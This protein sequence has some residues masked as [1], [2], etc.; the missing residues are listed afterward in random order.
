MPCLYLEFIAMKKI[1]PLLS[2]LFLLSNSQSAV[3]APTP[4][5]SILENQVIVTYQDALGKLHTAAS[6][7]ISIT[8]RKVQAA[9]LTEV[10]GMEQKVAAIPNMEVDSVHRLQNTGNVRS[11][12]QLTAENVTSSTTQ[13]ASKRIARLQLRSESVTDTIDAE[14]MLIFYDKNNNGIV[15]ADEATPITEI[16]L[17]AGEKANLIVR[18]MLPK[19]VKKDDRLDVTLQAKDKDNEVIITSK[20]WIK[21]TLTDSNTSD[22]TL[23]SEKEGGNCHAYKVIGSTQSLRWTD[24]KAQA[25]RSLYRGIRGHLV[26]ITDQP[27]QDFLCKITSRNSVSYWI[28]LSRSELLSSPY[29]WNTAEKFSYKNW[30]LNEPSLGSQRYIMMWHGGKGQWYDKPNDGGG[31]ISHYIIEFDMQCQQPKINVQLFGA[32]DLDCDAKAESDFGTLRLSEM[33]SGQCAIMDIIGVNDSGVIAKKIQLHH[34]LQD[35]MSYQQGSLKMCRGERCTLAA[36]GDINEDE[37][38]LLFNVGDMGLNAQV[39]ARFG[40]KID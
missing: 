21:L 9:T 37:N 22:L 14:Q 39:H 18:S 33:E 28:G 8:I 12:Y 24:A 1:I 20:N 31:T 23:W 15:D 26:S 7:I 2:F 29:E 4:A 5:G 10:S 35:F 25:D 36:N 40:V 30:G 38:R 11:T 6:N 19:L 34:Q 17:E 27:E 16:T 13:G 32:K 3:S